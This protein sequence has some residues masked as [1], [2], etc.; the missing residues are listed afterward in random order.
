VTVIVP[1]WN[2]YYFPADFVASEAIEH[3]VGWFLS[4]LVLAAIVRAP[5]AP[6][7]G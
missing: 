3:V 5:R 6:A 4:G 2:W 1:Y 7:A